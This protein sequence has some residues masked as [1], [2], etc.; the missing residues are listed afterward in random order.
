MRWRVHEFGH[1]EFADVHCREA[2]EQRPHVPAEQFAALRLGWLPE[3]GYAG[4]A[5]RDLRHHRERTLEIRGSSSRISGS[6]TG[7]PDRVD[8]LVG[9]VFERAFG[10]DQARSWDRAGGSVR[11]PRRRPRRASR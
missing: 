3:G 1:A 10:V 2:S 4:F 9:A 8:R 6:G 5:A 7:N 11:E